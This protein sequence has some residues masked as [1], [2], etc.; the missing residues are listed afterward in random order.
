MLT[1]RQALELPVFSSARLVAGKMGLDNPIHWVHIVDIPEAHY[2]WKRRGVLLLTAGFGLKDDEV[3]Q[4][5]LIP[6]LV[7]KGFAGMV[8]CVGYYFDRTPSEIRRAADAL[9][10]PVIETPPD[11]LFIE[12]TEAILERIVNQQFA[13]LQ[14]SNRIFAQLTELVLQGANLDELASRLADLLKRSITIEDPAFRILAAAQHGAVD[15]ARQRS[16]ANGRTTPEVA[17]HLLNAGIYTQLLERMSPLRVPPIPELNM[18]MER[19]VAPIIVDR[20]IHGYIWIIAGDHPL[21]ELDELAI[22]HGATVAA[23]ILFKDLAVRQA[24]ETLRGDFMERLLRGENDSGSFSEQAVQLNYHPDRP[25]QVLLIDAPLTMG[26]DTGFLQH[27]VGE[28][29]QAQ[30]LVSLM[31][32]RDEQLVVVLENEADETGE[33]IASALAQ[34]LSHPAQQVLIGVG[35]A[36][37]SLEDNAG[38]VRRSFEEAREALRIALAMG[39]NVGVIT[40]SGLG[41][42]YWLYHLPPEKWAGNLYLERILALGAYD[43]QRG[44]KLIHTLE[45]YLDHGGSLVDTAQVLFIHRNT[46]LHRLERIEKLCKVDLHDPLQRLNMHTAVKS[47]R[48]HQGQ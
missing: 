32:W 46:L 9:N 16:L 7:E 39:Q 33:Q 5:A 18:N 28:W 21:T 27:S 12:I 34:K 19:F 17:Q 41:L 23:L 38:C 2:E 22:S 4:A 44:T 10:F 14:Q 36:Y 13:V 15:E 43:E 11:L 3:R 31:T 47:Y 8:L 26:G 25:H 42:L 6:K 30:E 20:V 40:F 35:R 48:L 1:V 37:Q 29:L 24:E 45:T